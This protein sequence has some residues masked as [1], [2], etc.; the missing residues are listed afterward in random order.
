MLLRET[1]FTFLGR[2]SYDDMGLLYAEKDGHPNTPRVR[3]NTYEVAGA[4]GTLLFPGETRGTMAF[5]GTLY[6]VR[7]RPTQAEAQ[8]L[9]REVSA[10]LSGGRGQLI[11]DY[12]PDKYYLAELG[13][14]SKWS[15]KNWFGGEISVSFTAQPWARSVTADEVTAAVTGTS[16]SL[17]LT[18]HTGA[19]CPIRI[20]VENTGEADITGVSVLGGAVALSGMTLAAGQI[21][22]IDGEPPVGATISDM[23][24]EASAMMYATAFRQLTAQAGNNTVPVRLTYGTGTRGATVTASCRGMW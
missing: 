7:E 3:W 22:T 2:H 19:P 9:L 8:Q 15:L 14:E 23:G 5:E 12:E 6:P 11:F 4:D 1:G 24:T 18:A 13:K 20:Q 16:A 10:W 17:R 21:L